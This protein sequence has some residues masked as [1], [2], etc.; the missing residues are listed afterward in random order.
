MRQLLVGNG[1]NIQFDKI[2]Y[3]TRQ[4]MLRILKNC[5]K[6]DFPAHVIVQPAF[7]LKNYYGLLYL[8]ARKVISGEYD[9][10]AI[11]TGEKES[12]ASFKKQYSNKMKGLR[13]TD[14]GPEDYYLLH[15]LACH[16]TRTTNPDQFNIREAMKIAYFYAIY[17]DGKLN[18]LHQKYPDRFNVFL[19]GYDTI[20]T[21][22][23]DS[24]VDSVVHAEVYHIHGQFDK[25]AEV[26]NPDSFRNKLPDAPFRN[27]SIDPHFPYLYCN[28]LSTHCGAYKQFQIN[29]YSSANSVIEKMAAAYSSNA[30]AKVQ[31]DSW[32]DDKNTLLSNMGHAIKLKVAH[33][34]LRFSD[35]YHFDKLKTINGTLD[36]I[37]LSPW[38][39]FHIFE[40][41][42][43]SSV[44][45]CT[46]YYYSEE[47]QAIVREL[48]HD[49]YS[50]KRLAFKSVKDFWSEMYEE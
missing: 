34:E 31:I 37:G 30:E 2:N 38:N 26:Y 46:Y 48:L 11:G 23:Y 22:N 50:Q 1:I 42:D 3:T 13:I 10:Y 8:E 39:D 12:L 24:N 19:N 28:A 44:E 35:N 20:F 6:D 33:P 29:Q 16:K 9:I 5:D 21:T 45:M 17:N 7:F 32:C 47:Q 4:I 15:D 18:D 43:Q 25:L 36:I 14:I 49:I 27:S 41:I 40:S